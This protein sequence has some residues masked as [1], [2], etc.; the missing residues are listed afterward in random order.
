MTD[1]R[2]EQINEWNRLAEKA[3]HGILTPLEA[4]WLSDFEKFG[5]ELFKND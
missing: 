2:Q 5:E 3:T 1:Y 4:E